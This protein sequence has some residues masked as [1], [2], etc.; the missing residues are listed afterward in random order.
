MDSEETKELSEFKFP[1]KR[2]YKDRD[3]AHEHL[4]DL[5][6]EYPDLW[7]AIYKKK[8]VASGKN[9][10]EVKRV[11]EQKAKKERCFYLLAQ[12]HWY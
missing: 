2:F 11:G 6:K 1:P 10:A 5:A 8:V 7:V 3:W 9:L 12:V 4:N